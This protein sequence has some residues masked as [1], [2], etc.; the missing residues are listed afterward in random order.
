MVPES[1][2]DVGSAAGS[3]SH[4]LLPRWYRHRVFSS[5]SWLRNGYVSGATLLF[6]LEFYLSMQRQGQI[7]SLVL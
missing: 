5:V 7:P 6:L 4:D 3:V 1:D 2:K